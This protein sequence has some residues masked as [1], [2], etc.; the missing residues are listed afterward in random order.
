MRDETIRRNTLFTPAAWSFTALSAVVLILSAVNSLTGRGEEKWLGFFGF[1]LV[2][3]GCALLAC[4]ALAWKKPLWRALRA[5][6]IAA[7]V[8]AIVQIASVKGMNRLDLALG[9]YRMRHD[10][11]DTAGQ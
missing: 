5:F 11:A 7:A 10:F 8:A 9:D 1:Y 3:P 4:L 6:L 2:Y